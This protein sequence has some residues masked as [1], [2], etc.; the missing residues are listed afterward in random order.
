MFLIAVLCTMC[1]RSC[2][3][4]QPLHFIVSKWMPFFS[5]FFTILTAQ[6][7]SAPQPRPLQTEQHRNLLAFFYRAQGSVPTTN[8]PVLLK[9]GASSVKCRSRTPSPQTSTATGSV[10][11]ASCLQATLSC[12][13]LRPRKP[14]PSH[15]LADFGKENVS[16]P[17]TRL[18]TSDQFLTAQVSHHNCGCTE[19]K[20]TL[21]ALPLRQRRAADV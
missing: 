19:Y 21:L 17:R 16:N 12:H 6:S 20:S 4:T 13:L 7:G 10:R 14:V 11:G 8:Y 15:V 1:S 9:S 18:S 3:A 2:L 5:F